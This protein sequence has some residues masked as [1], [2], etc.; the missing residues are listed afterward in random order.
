MPFGVMC[1]LN[2]CYANTLIPHNYTTVKRWGRLFPDFQVRS[3]GRMGISVH[4][5]R[6]MFFYIIPQER[7]KICRRTWSILVLL[8]VYITYKNIGGSGKKKEQD[9]SRSFKKPICVLVSLL[10]FFFLCDKLSQLVTSKPNDYKDDAPG[11]ITGILHATGEKADQRNR[12]PQE[13]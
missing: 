3:C 12:S 8:R 13:R 4:S 5:I 9:I 2:P 10:S 1:S 6:F 11:D 7:L